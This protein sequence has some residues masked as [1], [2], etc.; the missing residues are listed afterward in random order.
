MSGNTQN[1]CEYTK[2]L[3]E[4][5]LYLLRLAAGKFDGTITIEFEVGNISHLTE[6][7]SLK[8]DSLPTPDK[9]GSNYDQS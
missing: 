9:L 1:N 7:R 3:V 2:G 8:P 6:H 4:V 5:L